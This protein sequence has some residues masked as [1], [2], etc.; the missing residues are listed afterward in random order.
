MNGAVLIQEKA[1]GGVYDI[2]YETGQ[3]CYWND[4]PCPYNR[5]ED[6]AEW[7]RGWTAAYRSAHDN[8]GN[9]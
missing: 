8:E 7:H 1:R 2:A 4:E 5:D 3:W 9:Q 6:V